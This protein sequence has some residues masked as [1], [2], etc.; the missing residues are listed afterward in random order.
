MSN[1]EYQALIRLRD[2]AE[3]R[4]R[5]ADVPDATEAQEILLAVAAI[6]DEDLPRVVSNLA[7]HDLPRLLEVLGEA[8][9]V[10]DAPVVVFAYTIKGFGLPLAGDPLNHSMLLTQTQMDE[11]R[12]HLGV[13]EDDIWAAFPPDSP[14]GLLCAE[15]GAAFPR[16]R[17]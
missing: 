14:E 10:A 1:E 13:P 6:A 11:L 16:R 15:R 5:L 8:D 9:A 12:A 3:L 17:P 7:G 2:G 4:R